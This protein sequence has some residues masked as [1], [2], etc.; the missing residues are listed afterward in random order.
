MDSS[1]FFEVVG[2]PDLWEEIR[3]RMYPRKKTCN[4]Y[5]FKS[6]DVAVFHGYF[7][8]MKERKDLEYTKN[9]MDWA[10]GKG[11]LEIVKFLHE[12]RK[13][14]CT[15]YAMTWAMENGHLHIVKFLDENRTEGCT[16]DAISWAA[17]NGHSEIVDF[18][19]EKIPF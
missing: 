6:G 18:L 3:K 5:K 2:N 1:L 8:L 13:E 15:K 11:Y 10:A 16:T 19:R 9:A 4:Y 17:W 7:G 12:N 14:G